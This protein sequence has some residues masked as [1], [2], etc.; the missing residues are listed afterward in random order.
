CRKQHTCRSERPR[1]GISTQGANRFPHDHDRYRPEY[2]R[3]ELNPKDRI[4]QKLDYGRNP[5]CQR[6]YRYVAPCRMVSLVEV[7]EFIAVK[8]IYGTYQRQLEEQ[9]ESAKPTQ[10]SGI[11]GHVGSHLWARHRQI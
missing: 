1:I 2:R 8:L 10:D 6:R 7:K 11:F 4:A 3:K 9:L 5:R